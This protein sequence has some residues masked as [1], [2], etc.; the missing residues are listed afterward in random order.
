MT[1]EELCNECLQNEP[2]FIR[3]YPLP[4]T[5]GFM[6]AYHLQEKKMIEFAI[7][8]QANLYCI[9]T[10]YLFKYQKSSENE[11]SLEYFYQEHFINKQFN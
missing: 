9:R 11:K 10:G 2:S 1:K 6:E 7:W 5:Q 3:E 4:Y 8:V